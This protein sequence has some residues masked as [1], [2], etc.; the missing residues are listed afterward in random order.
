VAA[1]ADATDSPY[2]AEYASAWQRVSDGLSVL[3][4]DPLFREAVTWQSPAVIDNAVDR[5]AA[6]PDFGGAV[7]PSKL[8]KSLIT[9]ASYV[10]RY[11]LKNDTIGFFGPVGWAEWTE[12]RSALRVE[13]GPT[14]LA[15]RSVYF[16]VWA[17]EAIARALLPSRLL[18]LRRA[19]ENYFTG[20]EVVTAAGRRIRLSSTEAK[21]MRACDGTVTDDWDGTASQVVE[22]LCQRGLILRDPDISYAAHPEE[23]LGQRLAA[24]PAGT[25]RARA[26]AAFERVIGAKD[27]LTAAAGKPD[28]LRAAIAALHERFT[29]V[30]GVSAT[31]RGG[32]AYAGRTPVYEDAVRDVITR[33]GRPLREALAP[34][35]ELLLTSARWLAT[36]VGRAYEERAR[37]LLQR[38]RRR[39]G[40]PTVPLAR[41]MSALTPDVV[42]SFGALPTLVQGCVDR[43]QEAWTR[44]LRPPVGTR[45]HEVTTSEIRAHVFREFPSR[46][47]PWSGGL[48][49]APDLMIA[50][51]SA[52]AVDAGRYIA[53]LGELHVAVN[54]LQA[55]VFVEQAPDPAAVLA[56]EH[57]DHRDGRVIS[58]PSR[59]SRGV[60][61]RTHPSALL[62]AGFTYWTMYADPTNQPPGLIPA[63]ALSVW[64]GDDGR[65]VVSHMDERQF[66]LFEVLGDTLT[67]ATMNAFAP[68]AAR[69]VSD[70]VW[71]RPRVT[72]D[73]LVI[74][75]ESWKFDPRAITWARTRSGPKRFRAARRWR[76]EW[77]LP[78]RAFFRVATE[79]KPRFIDFRSVVLVDLLGREVRR[80]ASDAGGGSVSFS[81]MLPDLDETW[82]VDDHGRHYTSEVRIVAVDECAQR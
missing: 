56:A 67:W 19:P 18:P 25:V 3:A 47:V 82:L 28:E 57:S 64:E 48:Q 71:R 62:P 37:Q 20:E 76:E 31:R 32:E 7:P 21:V 2:E 34:S 22:D 26:Q 1:A 36:E 13:A 49:H 42:F 78:E 53:V 39:T 52:E 70:G 14:L 41:L 8:R 29:E 74:S 15:R 16:E 61:S 9:V 69:E 58:L 6:A 65:L 66:D 35:L 11:A 77:G 40:E 24:L 38:I 55:R 5:I 27:A 79:T 50:A 54:T 75:R 12:D 63:G 51:P 60:N 17:V 73:R 10:Q 81:E 59:Q 43:F 45:R 30:T 23:Q 44:V 72:I 46:G 4:R 80:S 68:V 33:L